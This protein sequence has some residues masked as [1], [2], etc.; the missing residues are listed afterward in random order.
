MTPGHDTTVKL[1][2]L[3]LL[4]GQAARVDT[5]VE[6]GPIEL[7]GHL[8]EASP[9][10]ALTRLDVSRTVAGYALRLRFQ[11]EVAG[12]CMR[13][14]E[15]ATNEIDV[16]A[17]EVDQ[18]P[19]P[20]DE[21]E[22]LGEL[23]S[24]YVRGGDLALAAWARDALVLALPEPLL[25]REDCPGLCPV[26]GEPLAGAEPGAHDHEAPKDPRWAALDQL[27]LG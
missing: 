23:N 26:C 11:A 10:P 8:Y 4:S 5:Q 18:P 15:P 25:C 7:G 14:L 22:G 1:D 6:L 17:R 3:G 16:D 2:H 13:C 20:D 27:D 9:D 21:D 19:G 24:P 12:P